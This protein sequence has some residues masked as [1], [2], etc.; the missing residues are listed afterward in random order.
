M[1]SSVLIWMFALSVAT[2]TVPFGIQRECDGS[3]AR[4]PPPADHNCGLDTGSNVTGAFKNSAHL[5]IKQQGQHAVP[6]SL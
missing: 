6:Q 1:R 4:I 2:R 3:V 5:L